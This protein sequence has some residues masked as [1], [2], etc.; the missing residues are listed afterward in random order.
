[1]RHSNA[2]SE[3]SPLSKPRLKRQLALHIPHHTI[4]KG[5]DLGVKALGSFISGL[6]A[7]SATYD[8]GHIL[9]FNFFI[10]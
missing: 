10:C 9:T 7:S 3:E 8:L 6:G 4:V 1:M 2:E 5:G